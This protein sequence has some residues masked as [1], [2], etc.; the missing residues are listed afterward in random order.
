MLGPQSTRATSSKEDTSRTVAS[1]ST[2]SYN[3]GDLQN[4]R[5]RV[6]QPRWSGR[7]ARAC[8]D[9]ASHEARAAV[10]AAIVVRFSRRRLSRGHV[11]HRRH[12]GARTDRA[13]A[14]R[15]E[16]RSFRGQ[17]EPAAASTSACRQRD[18]YDAARPRCSGCARQAPL[19][20][21]R[22]AQFNSSPPA[23]RVDA[24]ASQPTNAA[25]DPPSPSGLYYCLDTL[26]FV[27]FFA[28]A[29]GA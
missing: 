6:Q 13:S 18:K 22:P 17:K 1:A 2:H 28:T 9:P 4:I 5:V 25:A 11:Q 10:V 7:A 26:A 19:L 27:F 14:R 3:M 29:Q 21:P 12:S 15:P 8:A 24:L 23:P 20:A 16:I